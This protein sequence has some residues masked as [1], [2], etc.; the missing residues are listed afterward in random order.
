MGRSNRRASEH[1]PLNIDALNEELDALAT[2]QIAEHDDWMAQQDDAPVYMRLRR[3]TDAEQQARL[4]AAIGRR[5]RRTEER[6][7]SRV[8]AH[9][10]AVGWETCMVPECGDKARNGSLNSYRPAPRDASQHLPLCTRHLVMVAASASAAWVNPDVVEA[11]QTLARKVV[12]E[13]VER[14]RK[15]DLLH[16]SNGAEQGQIYFVRLNGMVKVGWSSKLRSRLKSYGAS[17]EVLVHY[18]ASR[19]E[20]T[21]LHRNLRPYLAKGREWY[22]DCQ[23][24][25]D[26]VASLVKRYGEPT[27][28]PYWTEPKPDVIGTRSIA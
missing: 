7:D 10:D 3:E 13:Q 2:H 23:L 14:E 27:L 21:D 17:A 16:E 4:N 18:P 9:F 12:A 26:M 22:Q 11:R 19:Q 8:Q 25:T 15:A 5:R 1:D 28:L 6:I 24:V 20:E